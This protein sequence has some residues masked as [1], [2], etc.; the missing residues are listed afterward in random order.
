MQTLRNGRAPRHRCVSFAL[1]A[2]W[3]VLLHSIE[4]SCLRQQRHYR[5]VS[6]VFFRKDP[7]C[8]QI[9][10]NTRK[11][12]CCTYAAQGARPLRGRSTRHPA[13]A[14]VCAD[15]AG[16]GLGGRQRIKGRGISLLSVIL[17]YIRFSVHAAQRDYGPTKTKSSSL[18]KVGRQTAL[19][20]NTPPT[21]PV[22]H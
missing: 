18:K 15:S 9:F 11:R 14:Y 3:L 13:G 21:F 10:N 4:C 7:R 19:N 16:G 17:G 1:V 5:T 22:G 2:A 20:R 12:Q 6:V 8:Q